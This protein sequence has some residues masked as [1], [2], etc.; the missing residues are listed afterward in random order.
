[1]GLAFSCLPSITVPGQTRGSRRHH[2]GWVWGGEE[3]E[4]SD[5]LTKGAASPN[6]SGAHTTTAE[7]LSGVDKNERDHPQL[8]VHLHGESIHTA[9]AS[10]TSR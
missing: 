10:E 9:S 5:K 8:G 2:L 7:S 4:H 3:Q 1:M 6:S